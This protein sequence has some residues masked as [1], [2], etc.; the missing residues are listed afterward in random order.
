M[1]RWFFFLALFMCLITRVAAGT[2]VDQLE[3]QVKVPDDPRR[4]ISLAAG[5]CR[6]WTSLVVYVPPSA[7]NAAQ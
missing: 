7:L 1:I 5:C 4:V 2:F 3:R 6:K